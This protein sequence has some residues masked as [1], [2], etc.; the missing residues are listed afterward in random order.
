VWLSANTL[1]KRAPS[2]VLQQGRNVDAGTAA[3]V[4]QA[5]R[6][7]FVAALAG[8]NLVGLQLGSTVWLAVKATEV[9][10]HLR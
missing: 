8:V 5:S 3:A 9:T 1:S 7:P 2:A 4:L 10:A 6:N